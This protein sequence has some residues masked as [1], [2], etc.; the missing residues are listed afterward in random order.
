M[1]K[2]QLISL[3]IK[4]ATLYLS[5][6]SSISSTIE[7][8]SSACPDISEEEFKKL[9]EKYTIDEYT[10]RITPI[11]DSFFTETDLEESIQFY[12][13]GAGRKIF[14]PSFLQE[15]RKVSKEMF[16]EIEENF[17]KENEK[18]KDLKSS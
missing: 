18:A 2:E 17:L 14:D 3:F 6:K 1:R 13:K 11:I 9:K 4:K 7:W 10:K 5:M 12:T 8:A 16:L 15:I